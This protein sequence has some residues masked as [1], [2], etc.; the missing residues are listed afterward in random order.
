LKGY[1]KQELQQPASNDGKNHFGA[2]A[3]LT[4]VFFFWGFIAA[5]NSIFIPFC[6]NYFSLDQF[7]SQLIDFAFYGGYFFGALGLFAIGTLTKRDLIGYWGYRFS[8]VYGLLL[9][10]AGAASMLMAVQANTFPGML[11]GLFIVALGFAVQQ[12]AAQPFL[13][14][15]GKPESGTARVNLGGGVNSF[16]SAIGPLIVGLALFGTTAAVSEAQIK[17][18]P[19]DKVIWLYA[20][21]GALFVLSAALF[22]FSKSLPSGKVA[23]E[24]AS[25]PK[26]LRLMLLVFVVVIGAFIPV[27]MSYRSDF[28]FSGSTLDLEGYRFRWLLFALVALIGL[29]IYGHQRARKSEEG[30]GA[31]K[32]PQLIYG[33][34]AIFLYVGAEVSIVSN[35]SELLSQPDFGLFGTSEVAPFIALYWGSLM[36]GRW[37]GAISVFSLQKKTKTI[38]TVFMPFVALLV[39]F[40]IIKGS[41]YPIG[42]LWRY[43][44]LI[45]IQIAAFFISRDNPWRMLTVFAILGFI[46]MVVGM[47]TTG[48]V[49]VFAF[50]SGGLF[51]SVMWPAIFNLGVYGLGGQTP[52]G[53]SFLIMMILGGSIIPPIQ[54][55]LADFLQTGASYEGAG[56]HQSYWVVAICFAYLVWFGLV[57]GKSIYLKK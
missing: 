51:C 47:A 28:S 40:G 37:T 5:G 8:I 1:I 48:M 16:G 26:A 52:Q 32:Y 11:G 13:I 41:G 44:A 15:L 50:L 35:L 22:F 17:A 10:A 20:G 9:S 21:V 19:L 29:L 7:Q 6:K 12:T 34:I 55:K 46:A 23:N 43:A 56:I 18:L 38:L 39:V 45:P 2:L 31:F 53:S 49:A 36:I 3:T 14:S 54:G 27:F 24:Q 42:N 25:A 4:S 33:M 57:K 30:W